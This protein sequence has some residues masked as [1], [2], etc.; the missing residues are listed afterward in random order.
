M[1][2]TRILATVLAALGAPALAQTDPAI[3]A[4]MVNLDGATGNSS[5][6]AIHSA[7]GQISAD[8]TSVQYTSTDAYISATGV[9]S[10]AVG[11]FPVG[12]TAITNQNWLFRI[13]RA[14]QAQSGDKTATGLGQIGVMVNGVVFFNPLDAM[15]YNNRGI[16]NQNAVVVEAPTFDA[17]NGHP[18][19][20]RGTAPDHADPTVRP[21][22]S[23][24]H[25]ACAQHARL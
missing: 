18:A 24:A 15:S 1:K 12:P 3:T 2:T 8:V 14:P 19:P 23:P 20:P 21:G 10:H 25:P 17:A 6:P 13:P 16:W 5:D 11:P 22:G 7:V 9:P 4:W